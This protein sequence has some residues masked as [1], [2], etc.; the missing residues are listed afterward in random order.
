MNAIDLVSPTEGTHPLLL[1]KTLKK[2]S[3]RRLSVMSVIGSLALS[4]VFFGGSGALANGGCTLDG[5][6]TSGSPWQ[7][8]TEADLRKVGVGDCTLAG[9]YLQDADITLDSPWTPVSQ[10][11]F[12]GTY[13]GGN[14]SITG[15]QVDGEGASNQGMFRSVF[16]TVTRVNLVGASVTSTNQTL[17]TLVGFL[18]ETGLV[19][20]SNASG[21][22]SGERNVGGLVGVSQGS[23]SHSSAAVTVSGTFYYVGGLLGQ[24]EGGT[25]TDSHATGSVTST[26]NYVGGLVGFSW[27]HPITGGGEISESS[28]TGSVTG[29]DVVGGLVGLLESANI[30]ESYS[31]SVVVATDTAGGLV[32]LMTNE[33][34]IAATV[35]Y[36]YASGSVTSTGDYVGGL[37]GESRFSDVFASYASGA[38]VGNDY[39]GG[40]SGYYSGQIAQ[41]YSV[42]RV[43][44]TASVVSGA[45]GFLGYY[46]GNDLIANFWDVETSG[47]TTSLDEEPTELEGLSSQAMKTIAPYTAGALAETAWGIVPAS[48]FSAPLN[49]ASPPPSPLAK[50]DGTS[51]VENWGIG[52]SVNSGY[53]FLWWQTDSAVEQAPTGGS[54]STG[55]GFS[56]PPQT[57][58]TSSGTNLT[59]NLN[60]TRVLRLSGSNLNL[61]T[62]ARV[63][64]KRATI[65][66]A[67]SNSGILVISE[68]PLLPS[69]KYTLTLLTPTGLVA[70]EVE[71]GIIAKITRLRGIAASGKL[72]TK[73]RSVVRKQ[74]LTY[75]SAGTLRC[76]G[77]TTSSSASE[78]A[79]AKQKAEAACAYAKT[80]MPEL[81][82][83]S[84]SRT[85]T[86]QPA[87]NQ[88]VKLRYVK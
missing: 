51:L 74:N 20:Y 60:K 45:G 15:L 16:G 70:A 36:S 67:K 35:E 62:E 69:G 61:V 49:N 81:D 25:V 47:F 78:L 79:L 88:A 84:S 21:S 46:D 76:W 68:L 42:G 54:I 55:G 30:A 10:L 13:D 52:Q 65:N 4:S 39:V 11:G 40:L 27:L 59:V 32:G 48:Q 63:A 77:V 64:G 18:G 3:V 5:E 17:G 23:I 41:A 80:R 83:V 7:V 72:S 71:V 9:F 24:N 1:L 86:G 8:S 33:Y 31:S 56:A 38:V 82:V 37:V 26:S 22:V 29:E 58:I 44:A 87:R 19:S 57:T 85:G 43:R 28:A 66:F 12:T 34:V 75:A 14:F 6:G 50:P 73:V 2:H 53:P